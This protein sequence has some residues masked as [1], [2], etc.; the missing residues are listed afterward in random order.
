MTASLGISIL[1]DCSV[2]GIEML[3]LIC[4]T[5]EI[6]ILVPKNVFG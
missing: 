1:G 4:C 5:V 3:F 2:W 6:V